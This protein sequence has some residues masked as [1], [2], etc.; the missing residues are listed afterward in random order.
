MRPA[1]RAAVPGAGARAEGRALPLDAPRPIRRLSLGL[2]RRSG[3]DVARIRRRAA[4]TQSRL[5]RLLG[6]HPITISKWERG[7]LQ[8]SARQQ[9]L[10]RALGR[11]GSGGE[12]ARA[13]DVAEEL[14][15]LLNQAFIE[16]TEVEGMRLSASN[17]LRGKIV[18]LEIGPV[19]SRVVIQIAP[20]VRVTSVITSASVRRLGL[21]EGR[22]VVA[23]VKATDVILG[24]R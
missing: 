14:A 5:A 7:L 17:Q 13:V 19:S 15:G 2:V 6:V 11:G 16:V 21:R 1:R 18:E 4:L 23:I 20:R 10:L 3:L 9:A 24:S 8:P 12:A 22:A